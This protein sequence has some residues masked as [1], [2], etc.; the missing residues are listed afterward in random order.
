MQSNNEE[1]MLYGNSAPAVF[2]IELLALDLSS[3]TR[4]MGTL[5]HIE[6]A[7]DII[8][9]MLEVAGAEVN[10]RKIVVKSEEQ[11]RQHRFTT[12]PTIRIN[13]HDIA[14]EALESECDSC[15]D[16]CG[17]DEGTSC[18]V[19][20]YRGEEYTEAPVGLIVESVLQEIFG[21]SREP[22]RETPAFGGVPH[23]LRRFF[24]SKAKADSV[25]DP[26]CSPAERESCCEPT[27]KST[28]CDDSVPN[29][30]GCQ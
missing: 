5:E 22:I 10:V 17:C 30:C 25:A 23:N 9:P 24:Q 28:C 14:L 3:C 6:K 18:R 11:A 15:T 13:N 19:W 16:L 7:V 29:A 12:S 1:R 26:C 2:D 21:R 4:C 8:R 27:E 20:R